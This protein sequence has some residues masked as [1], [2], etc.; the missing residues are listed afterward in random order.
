MHFLVYS[1]DFAVFKHK[2]LKFYMD[3][4]SYLFLLFFSLGRVVLSQRNCAF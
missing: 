3:L 2:M 1:F 4:L